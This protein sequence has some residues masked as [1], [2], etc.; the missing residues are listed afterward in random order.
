[1]SRDMVNGEYQ[2]GENIKEIGMKREGK[3]SGGI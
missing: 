2:F 1:M 3:V